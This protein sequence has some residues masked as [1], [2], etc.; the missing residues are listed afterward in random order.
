MQRP[1]IEIW[2][3]NS[4]QQKLSAQW[5]TKVSKGFYLCLFCFK[6]RQNQYEI[7]EKES[8]LSAQWIAKRLKGV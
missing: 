5:I 1:Q 6:K 4:K 2:S 8:N 7:E 3:E